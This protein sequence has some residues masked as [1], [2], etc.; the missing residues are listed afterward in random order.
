MYV[1]TLYYRSINYQPEELSDPTLFPNK[2]T[3]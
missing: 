2:V 1:Y 3:F